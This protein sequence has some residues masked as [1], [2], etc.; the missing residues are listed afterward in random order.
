MRL[1]LALV[2]VAALALLPACAK[3]STT[4]NTPNGPVTVTQNNG[5]KQVTVKG[6]EGTTTIGVGAVDPST[7]GLP[8]YPGAT[9]SPS[10]SFASQT[11]QGGAQVV[12][13]QTADAFDKVYAFYKDKMPAGSEKMKMSSNGTSMATFQIG[14]DN[15]KSRKGVS[16]MSAQGKTNITLIVSSQP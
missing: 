9:T 14:G 3:K 10:G 7:L 13:M 6:S 16:I 2:L 15:D 8:I 4:Y 1:P 11:K 12:T 5:V